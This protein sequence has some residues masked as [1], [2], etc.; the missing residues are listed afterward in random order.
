LVKDDIPIDTLREKVSYCPITGKMTWKV[1]AARRSKIGD[2][3][4]DSLEAR[5]Y[6][7]G[8]FCGKLYQSHRVAWAIHHGEWPDGEI[9]HINGIKDDNRIENLRVATR[10]ENCRN[11]K[12]HKNNR[13]GL[14]GVFWH[15]ASMCWHA[16]I[17]VNQKIL[18]GS[19]STKEAAYEAYCLASDKY[20]KEFGRKS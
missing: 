16:V 2:L 7:R 11:T 6:R 17:N 14:K 13:S 18:L 4:F 12:M 19:F 10:S 9:D 15:K 1:R 20:H 3:A 8:F 5:G